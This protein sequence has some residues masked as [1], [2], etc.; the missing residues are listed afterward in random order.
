MNKQ[1]AIIAIAIIFLA[2]CSVHR[3]N[4]PAVATSKADVL[5]IINKAN[6]YWQSNNPPTVRAFWDHAAYH[7]GNMEAYFI[8][9]NEAYR[10][11][12]ETW[13]EHNQWKGAKS[14]NKSEW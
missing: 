9:K 5:A 12:S 6:S 11:Y 3:N 1:I 4:R 10:K 14:D 2:A 7:T 13:A 8:T